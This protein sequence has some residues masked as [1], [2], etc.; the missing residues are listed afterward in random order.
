L[1]DA[2]IQKDQPQGPSGSLGIVRLHHSSCVQLIFFS[3][4]RHSRMHL[5]GI[6]AR[7]ELDPRFPGMS[8]REVTTGVVLTGIELRQNHEC[9]SL[10]CRRE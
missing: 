9:I 6:Q 8:L 3:E 1:P 7:P 4:D 10:C 5:A 2:D